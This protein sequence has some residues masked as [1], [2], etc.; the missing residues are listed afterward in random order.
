MRRILL[1]GAL[2]LSVA[3]LSS[4]AVAANTVFISDKIPVELYSAT[5]QRGTVVT[6]RESGARLEVIET[7]GD[8]SKVRTLDGKEGW[9]KTSYL[10]KEKPVRSMYLKLVA[11]YKEQ[12]TLVD[13]LQTQLKNSVDANKPK[14]AVDKMRKDL[15]KAKTTI[16]GLDKQL[17]E[18]T[19]ALGDTQKQ[20][21]ALE[22]QQSGTGS[23][24]AGDPASQKPVATQPASQT[25][26]AFSLNYP[27]AVKW[28]IA[29]SLICI[30][31]GSYMG[32]SWLDS[33]IRR[34][35]G[36]VRIR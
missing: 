17:K 30:L 6:T 3:L 34:R 36:G 29:A 21:E 19:N 23:Q 15:A 31:L 7:D 33:R 10:S 28:T 4:E 32:Y 20:L 24:A 14:A 2:A 8:Y 26:P 35:H 12:Q 22:N 1:P 16:A 9:V 13:Q 5:L 27:I 25:S 18:K 11:K